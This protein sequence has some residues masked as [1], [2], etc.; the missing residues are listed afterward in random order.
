MKIFFCYLSQD[1]PVD[2]ATKNRQEQMNQNNDKYDKARDH[3]PPKSSNHGNQLNP[4]HAGFSRG[5][6]SNMSGGTG[7]HG[8]NN[9]HCWKAP[10]PKPNCLDSIVLIQR[11]ETRTKFPFLA[12][13]ND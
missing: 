1:K 3:R 4:N 5:N 10:H 8:A 9:Q 7:Y 6:S 13:G 2:A 11:R 12:N